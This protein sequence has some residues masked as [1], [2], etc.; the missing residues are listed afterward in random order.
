MGS[1]PDHLKEL[2]SPLSVLGVSLAN[3]RSGSTTCVPG[4]DGKVE[5]VFIASKATPPVFAHRVEPI[6]F[7]QFLSSLQLNSRRKPCPEHPSI[8]QPTSTSPSLAAIRP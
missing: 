7:L 6:G 5:N 1:R 2:L 8:S 4:I 3:R